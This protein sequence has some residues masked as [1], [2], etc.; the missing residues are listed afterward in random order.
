M[1]IEE[2][3]NEYP[4][5]RFYEISVA[6]KQG[7]VRLK[8]LKDIIELADKIGYI[9][10]VTDARTASELNF[11]AVVNAY[12]RTL[13]YDSGFL[14]Y[15]EENEIKTHRL[16]EICSCEEYT[17]CQLFGL[18]T[19]VSYED[20]ENGLETVDLEEAEAELDRLYEECRRKKET[21]RAKKEK[22]INNLLAEYKNK[23][24]EAT[25]KKDKE[26]IITL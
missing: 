16:R 19:A 23:Y 15:L 26:K 24:N 8:Y 6:P 17:S 13:P 7:F 14:A 5:V 1:K 25:Y 3:K 10:T 11:R 2:I 4:D 12:E 18:C 9:E 20:D 21:D 22:A